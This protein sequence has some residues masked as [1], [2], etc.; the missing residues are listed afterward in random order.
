MMMTVVN[1][2]VPGGRST[3]CSPADVVCPDAPPAGGQVNVL[4]VIVLTMI[5]GHDL[6]RVQVHS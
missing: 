6:A 5:I 4:V 1:G 2:D 3:S